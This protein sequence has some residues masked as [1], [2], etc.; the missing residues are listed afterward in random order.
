MKT[1]IVLIISA[2]IAVLSVSAQEVYTPLKQTT[3][4]FAEG[5]FSALR[6]SAPV[7]VVYT[8][9]DTLPPTV[10]PIGF[11][12]YVDCMDVCISSDTLYV[13]LNLPDYMNRPEV[14][15]LQ[16]YITGPS[17]AR[18]EASDDCRLVTIGDQATSDPM[19]IF[20][21]RGANIL[22]RDRIAAPSVR[23]AAGFQSVI[24]LFTV[25]TPDMTALANQLSIVN[26]FAPTSYGTSH[27]GNLK[28]VSKGLST[29][30]ISNVEYD[31][32]SEDADE[33]S[34]ITIDK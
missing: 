9:N 24:G 2:F 19:A 22:V 18:I 34:T 1:K 4:Q 6:C 3:F 31:S 16:V 25:D 30:Y 13:G 8:V 29:V 17:L 26:V 5:S 7:N 11:D 10:S 28:L 27:I 21:S 14:N 33:G 23:L 12:V 20:A 15:Q 32:V